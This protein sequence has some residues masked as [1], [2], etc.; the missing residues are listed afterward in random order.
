MVIT[1]STFPTMWKHA[2]VIPILKS[3][4]KYRPISI[5]PYLAKVFERLI[6]T[7]ISQYLLKN[8]LLSDRQS[9]FRPKHSCTTALIDVSEELRLNTDKNMI[10]ILILLDHSK[11]FDTVEHS[12]LCYKLKTMCYFSS[13][14]VNLITSYLHGRSQSVYHGCDISNSCSVLRGVPQGST[15]GPLLFSIYAN[16]LPSQ[17]SYCNIQMYADDVQLYISCLPSDITNCLLKV[18]SD[19]DKLSTWA[20]A[21]SLSL[22]ARKSKAIMIGKC[23]YLS[24][25]IPPILIN[26]SI[27][28]VVDAAKNLGVV[29]NKHLN[30]TD[31][32]N[33][34]C[35]KTY[36]MLRNLWMTQYYTP[37]HVRMLL[38]KT[39]LLPSLLYGCELFNNSDSASKQ[40]LNVTFNNIA[41]YIFGLSRYHT[42][43]Q[44]SK[45]IYNLSFENILN[46][47]SLLLLHK[48]IYT[49]EPAYLYNRI[50]FS[51]SNRGKKINS[52]RYQKL[53]SERHF[54]INTIRLW[55][56]LPHNIQI[57]SNAM[58]FKLAILK[59]FK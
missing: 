2:K 36:A 52:M 13:T 27:I 3:D 29:F 42:I 24:F 1:T 46:C 12:T 55:N 20:S 49:K 15:L 37:F 30:W 25:N 19:L 31:H 56:Q 18:N 10:S 28:E 21:N 32:I 50:C 58:Q 6:Y 39:Y 53:I 51:I 17:I 22:N 5:L 35:G 23:N 14:A 33:A 11:A 4:K 47:R 43:T 9:G 16:D 38:A 54:F 57:L 8:S 48:L 34:N 40:K 59:F 41:R 44:F 7:Q 26:N 45:Q